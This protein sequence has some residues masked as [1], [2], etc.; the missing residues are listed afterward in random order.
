MVGVRGG[1]VTLVKNEWPHVTSSH[2]SLHRYALASKTT[3][4]FDGSHGRRGQSD[5]FHSCN[6]QKSPALPASGQGNGS[7]TSGTSVLY[8]G[9][10]AVEG[11]MPLSA[12]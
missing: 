9:S 6:G 8:Q 12:V 2:C 11:Q 3:S 7:A 4:A 5:Q 1:F 10:T